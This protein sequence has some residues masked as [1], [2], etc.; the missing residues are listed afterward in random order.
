MR[1]ASEA[2][3]PC[4]AIVMVATVSYQGSPIA[5]R[6]AVR[7]EGGDGLFVECEFPMPVGTQLEVTIENE[8]MRPARVERV[9]E[10]QQ[11]A[12]MMLKW[13]E[14]GATTR[15]AEGPAVPVAAADT[16]SGPQ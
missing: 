14:A 8:R 6:A 11:G 9:V 10:A 3:L 4:Y 2:E 13:V 5:K 12:G 1:A 7:D 16:P 15:A